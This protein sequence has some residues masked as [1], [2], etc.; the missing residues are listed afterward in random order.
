[1]GMQEQRRR[2]GRAI[3]RIPSGLFILTATAGGRD[4]ASLVSWVQQAAFEPPCLTVALAADRPILPLIEL[5]GGF[6]LSIIA[7]GQSH[8]LRKYARGMP[9][10]VNPFEGIATRPSPGGVPV[11]AEAAAWLECRLVERVQFPAD[12]TLI[13]GQITAGEVLHD[14]P[15]FTHIRGNG[16]H[17]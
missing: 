17:Y 12:H 8:L 9:D 4:A 7:E 13:I 6:A 11:L 15:P 10:A 16:F 5:A 2:L 3:G 14:L 1:M